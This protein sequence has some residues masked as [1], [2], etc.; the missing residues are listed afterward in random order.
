MIYKDPYGR[1]FDIEHIYNSVGKGWRNILEELLCDLEELGWDGN[2]HQIKEKFGGLRFYIGNGTDEIF[3]RIEKAQLE[4]NRTCEDCGKPGEQYN[5]GWI[6][7]RCY[8]C[9]KKQEY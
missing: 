5:A 6:K 8:D 3:D 7:T 1:P 2:I 9:R 4:S